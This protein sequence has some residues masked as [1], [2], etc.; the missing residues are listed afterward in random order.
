MQKIAG[1]GIKLTEEDV[2]KVV[3]QIISD[4]NKHPKFS[5]LLKLKVEI[6]YAEGKLIKDTLDASWVAK[7]LPEKPE[8]GDKKVAKK[9]QVE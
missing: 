4:A 6:P 8:A 2:K 9:K 1:I 7:G 5:I 3:D